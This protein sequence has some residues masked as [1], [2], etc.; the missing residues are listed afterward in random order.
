MA[1][2]PTKCEIRVCQNG[3]GGEI[4]IKTNGRL[5]PETPNYRYITRRHLRIAR[6]YTG[7]LSSGD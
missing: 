3:E 4:F 2:V 6:P 7:S 5:K 1:G